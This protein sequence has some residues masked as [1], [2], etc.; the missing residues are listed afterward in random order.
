MEQLS[1]EKSSNSQSRPQEK[2]VEDKPKKKEGKRG[3]PKGSKNK[4]RKEIELPLYLQNIQKMLKEVI[5]LLGNGVGI[6]FCVLDGAF[7]NNNALQMV[8]QCGLHL[9]SKLRSDSAL[10]FPY[11]GEQKTC[12]QHRKYGDKLDYYQLPAAYQVETT[13]VDNI[14]TTIYQ[15]TVWHQ[16]FPDKLNVVAIVKVNLL[17]QQQAHVLLVR[18]ELT[19]TWSKLMAAYRLRF[20]IE[21][22]FRDA[23]QHWGLEDFMNVKERPVYNAANLA[24]FMVNFSFILRQHLQDQ[25]PSEFSVLDLKA[26]FRGRRYAQE[27]LKFLPVSLDSLLIEHC[28]AKVGLLGAI[29]SPPD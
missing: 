26:R 15:M 12:G 22:N 17:T 16:L 29:H 8:R 25:H 11:E 4:N 1:K 21:F 14:R 13:R 24:M 27:V 2:G 20:Q 10:Y 5:L 3:R 18:R 19:L 28:F 9:I 23:K 7:G 6:T